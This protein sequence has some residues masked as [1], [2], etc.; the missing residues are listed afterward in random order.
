MKI[1]SRNT[2]F[3]EH[4]PNQSGVN[5]VTDFKLHEIC[6]TS[7]YD[8]LYAY[9][10]QHEAHANEARFMRER[11][12]DPLALVANYH[13]PP[14]HFNNYHSQYTT[15]QYQQQFSPSLAVLTFLPGND[16]IA[17]MNKKMAFMSAVFSPRY[18]STNNQ[19]RSS[20][21]LR[22]QT[23]IQDGR[24]TV[25]QVQGRQGQNVISSGSQG[26]VSGLRGNTLGQP[27]VMKCYNCQAKGKELDEEQL[28][29]LADPR[30]AD[31]KA[32]L[33][34]NLS[35]CDSDVLSEVLYSNTFQN[36]MMN[37]SVQELQY[38][39][40]SPIIDY[41][42]N[43]MRSDSNIIPLFSIS[44]RNATCDYFGKCFVPQQKPSAEQMFWLQ[45]S[46]KKSEEP[47]TSNTP[48]KIKVPSE[49]SKLKDFFKEFE[50]DLHD[51][52]T[53][54]QTVF[55]QIEAAV[56]QCSVD[57]KCCEIQQKQFLIENDRLLDKIIS[58]KIVN[59]VLNSS[60]VICAFQQKNDE[61]VVCNKCQELEAE[62]V[63][64][65]DAYIE[66]SKQF[67][68][69]EQHCISLESSLLGDLAGKIKNIDGKMIGKDG[70]PM[71]A[72]RCVR[73]SDATKV[74]AYGGLEDIGMVK[75][76]VSPDEGCSNSMVNDISS[77]TKDV[78]TT[79]KSSSSVVSIPKDAVD[80][81]KLRFVKILYGYS[82]G[83]DVIAAKVGKL[84]RLDAH[85]TSI[86]LNSW[87]RSDYARALVEISV[88][89]PLVNSVDVEIPLDEYN[90]HV[91]VKVDIEYEWQPPRCGTCKVF[92]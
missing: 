15:P 21:N 30:V 49:L 26:N 42:D 20:S 75:E 90:G 91:T 34:T 19:L 72:R 46:N 51:E 54:V 68:N 66:L 64:N 70:K 12:S 14:S 23:T 41:P 88:E 44:R 27:K 17:C 86:C 84:I 92:V 1:C 89:S 35:S 36:D 67:S 45:S 22:N 38:S 71:V 6:L 25:Q 59:I 74:H 28:A 37:Q 13:Q 61:S 24:V 76:I 18:P 62:F 4:P 2:M 31:A 10:E 40:Q 87:R 58:Q 65:N 8:Q 43:E 39:E 48:V 81:I 85:T 60:V 63:K 77:H 50:N 5:F 53:E 78:H 80:E 7:N 79:N 52:I 29:F 32:V 83:L 3:S 11:F 47:S 57:R 73:S 9:L 82:V 56:E 16:P 33:M 69:I 55:T